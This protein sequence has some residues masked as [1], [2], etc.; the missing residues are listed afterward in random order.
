ML[1]ICLVLILIAA[2]LAVLLTR[3]AIGAGHRL[4]RIDRPVATIAHKV[5][6]ASVPNTGGMG[7]FAAFSLIAAAGFLA[8]WVLPAA[9]LEALGPA[10][11]SLAALLRPLTGAA[12]AW[13][14]ALL[15]LHVLGVIDDRR[16]LSA[17]PKLAAQCLVALY[18]AVALDLRIF[19]FLDALVPGGVALSLLLT[20]LWIVSITNAMNFLDNMDGLSA[21]VGAVIA[22]LYLAAA[23]LTEQ[24]LIAAWCGALAGCL[25]GFL[26][27]N[28]HP[29]RV[30]MG[31]G[32]S[33]VLG[34][35]LASIS[36][37]MTYYEPGEAGAVPSRTHAVLMPLVVFAVPLYDFFSV[38]VLRLLQGRSPFVG[39]KQ[40]FSHRLVE[41][42]LSVRQAVGL[43][44]LCTLAT[45]LGGV[46]FGHLKPWQAGVIAAQVA[47][48][49]ALLAMLEFAGWRR[50]G[51]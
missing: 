40:H 9:A 10:A 22:T 6:A 31:D 28:F 15:A 44:W 4:G 20:V 42:G 38:V 30:Y 33:L 49:V 26:I 34:L 2:A 8:A 23:L 12:A 48:I 7:I 11:E 17:M 47:C 1:A 43:V 36:I 29:A 35:S 3:L 45:G 21:G 13:W 41:R 39:D 51:A 14:V 16:N 37:A 32:G 24:W 27:F 19:H 18:L 50:R 46:L 25:L 5:D